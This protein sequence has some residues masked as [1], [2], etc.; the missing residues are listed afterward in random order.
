M[1]LNRW[2][3]SGLLALVATSAMA[4]KIKLEFW[5]NSLHPKFDAYFKTLEQSYEAQ[6]PN[7]DLVWVDIDWD[8]FEPKLAA[9]LAAGNA[10]AVVNLDVPQTFR[11]AQQRMI[12]PLDELMGADRSHYVR[13]ALEDITFKGKLYGFPWYNNANVLA[14]N[15]DLL[16]KAGLDANKPPRTLDEQ[17]AFAK[18]IRAK[19]GQAGLLPQLG[20]MSGVFQ[21]EG[22][23]LVKDGKAVFNSP[24]HVALVRKLA[25]AYRSGALAKDSLFSEDNFQDSIKLYNAGKLGM[26]EAAPSALSRTRDDAKQVYASTVVQPA[27]LGGGKIAKGGYLFTFAIP[28]TTDKT[29]LPEAVK[30]AKF[31]TND[32]NQLAF[33]KATGGT[34]PSTVGALADPFFTQLPKNPGA[35]DVARATAARVAPNVRTLELVGV[36]NVT[37][38]SKKL[39]TAIEAAVTG[40]KDPK[41]A[42]DEAAEFWNERLKA[43]P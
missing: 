4:D 37:T 2:V 35:L 23:A 22:L 6:N 40:Q 9:A 28:V 25:D 14:L 3:S 10:P 36:P 42:L 11:F 21:G 39:Q 38:L 17:L 41:L 7:V 29:K 31:I 5:T 1:K 33:S 30:F 43:T 24:Q 12:L 20:K 34:Y 18:Q 15:A 19:T 13:G 32:V 8:N 16:K 26:M 27:P